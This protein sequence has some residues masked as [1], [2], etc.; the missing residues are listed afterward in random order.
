[1]SVARHVAIP[2]GAAHI[3]TCVTMLAVGRR[4]R[5]LVDDDDGSAVTLVPATSVP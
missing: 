3:A 5:L 4:A 2:V 1:M